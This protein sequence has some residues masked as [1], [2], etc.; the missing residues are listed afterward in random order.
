MMWMLA[1]CMTASMAAIVICALM[2]CRWI[3]VCGR[4]WGGRRMGC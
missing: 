4:W 3:C 1:L 2:V